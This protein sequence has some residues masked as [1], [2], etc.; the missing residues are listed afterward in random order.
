LSHISLLMGQFTDERWSCDQDKTCL[1][2]GK[3]ER[4][5]SIPRGAILAPWDKEGSVENESVVKGCCA[6]Q[7]PATLVRT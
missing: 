5:R 3:Q 6:Q 7:Q 1:R 4:R 2:E